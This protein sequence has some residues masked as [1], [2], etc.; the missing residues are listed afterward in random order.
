[1]TRAEAE[2]VETIL[3]GFS[4]L[5]PIRRG[6]CGDGLRPCPFVSCRFHLYLDVSPGTGSIKLNF[7]D[8][9]VWELEESC[10]L[11]VADRGG[12][13]LEQVGDYM[14]VTRERV[15]QIETSAQRNGRRNGETISRGWP[16][17]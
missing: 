6:D 8:L 14:N 2:R 9:E 10:V 4:V 5:R 3:R 7:P 11:D 17:V 1:M 16:D 15:R 12:K 13:T